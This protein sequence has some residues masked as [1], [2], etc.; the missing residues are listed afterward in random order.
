M[1]AVRT[2]FALLANA[3]ALPLPERAQ[4][5]AVLAG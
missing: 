1:E 4:A 2:E 3:L 5:A